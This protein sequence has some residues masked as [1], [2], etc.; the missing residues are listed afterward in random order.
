[1]PPVAIFR[2]SAKGGERSVSRT[3]IGRCGFRIPAEV[4]ILT[5]NLDHVAD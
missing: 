5:Q 4:I 2:L 3:E 1:M